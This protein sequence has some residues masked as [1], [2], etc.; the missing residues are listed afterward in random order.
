MI[1]LIGSL[2]GGCA[3]SICGGFEKIQPSRSDVLTRET[4]EQILSHNLHGE[5]QG[6]WGANKSKFSLPNFG[7]FNK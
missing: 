5:Q 1:A 2:T 7:L 4:K 6:C 3:T